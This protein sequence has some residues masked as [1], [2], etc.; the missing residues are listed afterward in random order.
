[1]SE[2]CQHSPRTYVVSL[3]GI[4]RTYGVTAE[5]LESRGILGRKDVELLKTGRV[6]AVRISTVNVL[7]KE[8]G[9]RLG[10][11]FVASSPSMPS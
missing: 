11:L 3:E 8:I 5:D 1:M 6:K 4:E 9:C 7:C 2:T 10:D